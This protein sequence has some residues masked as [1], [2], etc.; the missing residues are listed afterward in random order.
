MARTRAQA[1]AEDIVQIA[2]QIVERH[3]GEFR[4]TTPGAWDALHGLEDAVRSLIKARDDADTYVRR[5][6]PVTSRMAAERAKVGRV[7]LRAKVLA[8]IEASGDNGVADWELETLTGRSHQ[9]VSSARRS[10]VIA[11]KVKAL[12]LNP[13]EKHIR[14]TVA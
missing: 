4:C 13:G 1:A 5:S 9:S 2:M 11:G 8:A 3:P 14:W 7:T 12:P 10:H 6:A